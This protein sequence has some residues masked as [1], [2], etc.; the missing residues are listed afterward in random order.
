MKDAQGRGSTSAGVSEW[1]VAGSETAERGETSVCR[2]SE[3]FL[4]FFLDIGVWVGETRVRVFVYFRIADFFGKVKV[5]LS[6][7]VC[8]IAHITD[9]IGRAI[10]K[11]TPTPLRFA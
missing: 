9:P 2:I 11:P 1:G 7:G 5:W 3:F 6:E 10:K 4:E 8:G